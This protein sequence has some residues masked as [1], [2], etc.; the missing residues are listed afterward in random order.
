MLFF[1]L[2][3]FFSACE[4]HSVP[5]GVNEALEEV[6]SDKVQLDEGALAM[7][8]SEDAAFQEFAA[9]NA[10]LIEQYQQWV[11]ALEEGEKAA[12]FKKIKTAMD[13]QQAFAPDMRFIDSEELAKFHASQRQIVAQV[14]Q[15]YAEAFNPLDKE[16]KIAVIQSAL[17]KLTQ[18]ARVT[19][20]DS[21][22][23][24]YNACSW[25]CYDSG[26]S[27]T[28]YDACWAGYVAC[29]AIESAN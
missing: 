8:I 15:K 29:N 24:G 7:K 18:N 21:C 11:N 27:D 13:A 16:T 10:K 17:N 14:N 22:A 28:C 19:T 2:L 4:H 9:N 3:L 1:T 20:N 25:S 12:Y 5:D 6:K 23:E 26:G